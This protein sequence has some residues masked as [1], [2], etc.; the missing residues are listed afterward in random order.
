MAIGKC[1]PN[2]SIYL[3][4]DFCYKFVLL[5]YRTEGLPLAQSLST[6]MTLALTSFAVLLRLHLGLEGYVSQ[7]K[8]CTSVL[9]L[10][11]VLGSSSGKDVHSSS[12]AVIWLISAC[13]SLSCSN[14]YSW[15]I[16]LH[17]CLFELY[18]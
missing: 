16:V 2:I 8:L 7:G 10:G 3:L 6:H 17:L 15:L 13:F 11:A 14:C 18:F 5:I 9:Q 1:S 4:S 12:F